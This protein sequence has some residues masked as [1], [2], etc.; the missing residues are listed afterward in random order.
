M[1]TLLNRRKFVAWTGGVLAGLTAVRSPE[2]AQASEPGVQKNR[3]GGVIEGI[4]KP[5]TVDLRTA[6]GVAT[7]KF[8]ADGS[9]EARATFNRDGTARLADFLVGDPVVVELRETG[10]PL[11]GSHMEI[12]YRQIEGTI[13]EKTDTHL[14]TTAGTVRLAVDTH[15]HRCGNADI[16]LPVSA[17]AVGNAVVIDARPD[18][19]TAELIARQICQRA[20]G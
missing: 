20:T 6:A 8:L 10:R 1:K 17:L 11:R 12:L 14:A 15:V 18:P 16:T 3:I 7:V 4:S 2:P 13:T 9:T 5:H 19:L